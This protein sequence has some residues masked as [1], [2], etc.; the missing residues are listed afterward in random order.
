MKKRETRNYS[1]IIIFLLSFLLVTSLALAGPGSK[2]SAKAKSITEKKIN[3]DTADK[4]EKAEATSTKQ[5]NT[6]NKTTV[7][8]VEVKKRNVTVD[9]KKKSSEKKNVEI[10]IN[11][12][13]N[14]N[15][16]K[17][18][19]EISNEKKSTTSSDKIYENQ[20]YH[21]DADKNISSKNELMIHSKS[22]TNKNTSSDN[23]IIENY[24][25]GKP[26]GTLSNYISPR[27]KLKP[28]EI[29]IENEDN[30]VEIIIYNNTEY[31]YYYGY[32]YRPWDGYYWRIWPPFGFR[33]SWLPPYYYAFWWR[34]VEYY[35]S[36]NVYY[37]YIE[38]EDEYV[39]V[40]PPIGA[41]V[42]TIPDYSEKLIVEGETYF[43]AD[44]IQYKAVIVNDEIW[45]KVIKVV[46]ENEYATVELPVGALIEIIPEDRE[47]LFIDGETY[48]IAEDVQYKAVI[49]NDEIWFKVLKVG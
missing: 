35:Y 2:I 37:V 14:K 1:I 49:V 11:P 38:E 25:K 13:K 23:E 44:G 5:K 20:R 3:E 46:D 21:Q 40:R 9:E 36:C 27:E 43:L 19:V 8:D 26:H 30:N 16:E 32:Y 4:K 33:I 22:I 15:E 42:E 47:L 41:V 12:D 17:T 6:S 24:L 48:F 34:D 28:A 29:E 45:F 39:V 31:H 18:K 7:K 10:I